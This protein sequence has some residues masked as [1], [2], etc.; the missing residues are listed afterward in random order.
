MKLRLTDGTTTLE[1]GTDFE[2][3]RYTPRTPEMDVASDPTLG[4]GE[5]VLGAP[6]RNV[7]EQCAIYLD[8]ANAGYGETALEAARRTLGEIGRLL[9]AA[10]E[11]QARGLGPRVWVA[12]QVADGDDWYRSEVLIG[13]ALV[14]D[15]N[16]RYGLQ[17]AG[18]H[19]EVTLIWTRRFF[20]EYGETAPIAL[21][22]NASTDPEGITNDDGNTLDVDGDD[23]VG[24]LPAPLC[25]RVT[26][27]T[28]SETRTSTV[29]V[30]RNERSAPSSYSHHVAGF[31]TETVGPAEARIKTITMTGATLAHL[32]GNTCRLLALMQSYWPNTLWLRWKVYFSVTLLWEG[33]WMQQGG[34]GLKD[35]G[36][37]ALPPRAIA[38]ADPAYDLEL[39]LY[40]RDAVN[41]GPYTFTWLQILPVDSWR[42][43]A[44]AGYGLANGWAVVDDAPAGQVYADLGATTSVHYSARGGAI[45]V[46]PGADQRLY[47]V[48]NTQTGT[49][50]SGRT[51][52]VQA[53]YRP[54]R[55]AL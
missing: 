9:G 17:L 38:G 15:G 3:R 48:H 47:V 18:E 34:L 23:V 5:R 11:R 39:R 40:A 10:R 36:A 20:W 22:L 55:I 35:M 14:D 1:S 2:I 45:A 51:S 52:T 27:T 53:W 46:T 21:P 49:S 13:R 7:A 8:G 26:N 41:A 54:R 37:V 30:A 43:L 32:A 6:Y 44:P 16:L 33:P 4:D 25:L 28:D 42:V 31:T 19:L 50:V 29:Y 12:Q 24:D